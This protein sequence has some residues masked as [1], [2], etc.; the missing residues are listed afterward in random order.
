ML[1]IRGNDGMFCRGRVGAKGLTRGSD[2]A[3]DLNAIL[4]VNAALDALTVPVVVA[5][6]GEALGFG[7]GLTAQADYAVAAEDA[8]LALP[9][10]SHGL[11]PLIVLSYLFRFVPYKRAFELAVSSRAIS[12]VE[13]REA[14]VVTEVVASGAAVGAGDG[15]GAGVP[16]VRCEVAGAAAEVLAACGGG[17]FAASERACRRADVDAAG[18]EG[19]GRR[20]FMTVLV[21]GSSGFLGSYLMAALGGRAHGFDVAAPGPEAVAVAPGAAMSL[22]QITDAARLFDVCRAQSVEAI[23][24]AA[25]MVGLELSLSQPAATYATNVMGFVNVCEAARQAGVR[26][27]V[28]MSSNAAYHGGAGAMLAE[29]DPVFSIA[30]GN[31]AGHYGT[32]KMMQEAVALAY[33]RFHGLDVVILRVTAIYGFGM[34]SPM[35]VKPMVE[36]AV[37]GRATR[38]AT[39][40]AMKR[41][42][43]YVLDCVD[44]VVRA[45]DRP[46]TQRVLNV[47]AGRAVT[48]AEVAA[49]VRRVIP[50]ADI[51]IGD[52]L[53]L[54]EVE[55]V[56]MRAPL[57]ISAAEAALGWSPAWPI[58]AGIADYA[59]R[60]R[61]GRA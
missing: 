17:A 26:R 41:D 25:G 27:L 43:T 48:A 46:V 9:E 3:A 29:T 1:V 59:A 16:G 36:D 22:G 35:Y 15:G 24:H 47:S 60:L 34:R 32:S 28:L 40:G 19:A 2:V 52:A 51:E 57:D 4:A 6:E 18:G 55:N 33:Q 44:A 11:P 7:F 31:P 39:G 54:L 20:A 38:F 61:A 45:L 12:A 10:M 8:V 14:G 42:Y 56:K 53:T 49:I 50:G 58:E 21:T 30:V 23:V 37:L 5:V 13:A